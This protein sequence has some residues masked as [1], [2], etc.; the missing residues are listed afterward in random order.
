MTISPDGVSTVDPATGETIAHFRYTTAD[1]LEH[2]LAKSW[3]AQE[4]WARSTVDERIDGIKRLGTNL[5]ARRERLAAQI[6][7]EM[8][9]PITQA[10]AEIDKCITACDYYAS[11]LAANLQAVRVGMGTTVKSPP[12]HS[13]DR[14]C[15]FT[16]GG[17]CR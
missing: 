8:G 3:R 9:K 15:A 16:P 4:E 11:H 5:S 10:R 1:D 7:R 6:V 2:I 13:A 12:R 17:D 14:S